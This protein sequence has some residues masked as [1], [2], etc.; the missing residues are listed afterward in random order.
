MIDL[1]RHHKLQARNFYL[2][3]TE[4]LLTSDVFK[5]KK[6]KVE[7]KQNNILCGVNTFRKKKEV[8]LRENLRA[9]SFGTMPGPILRASMQLAHSSLSRCFQLSTNL[10]KDFF[11]YL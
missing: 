2:E 3:Q 8:K 7:R 5:K 6:N 4:R 11:R 10:D 1:Q 9:G